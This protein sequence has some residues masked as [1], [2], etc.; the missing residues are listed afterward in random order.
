MV[1]TILGEEEG[2]LSK[3]EGLVFRLCVLVCF[4]LLI[5]S[6]FSLHVHD[7][8]ILKSELIN[9]N[10][11]S[12]AQFHVIK[13]LILRLINDNRESAGLKSQFHVFRGLILRLINDKYE[14]LCMARE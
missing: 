9:N 6:N 10:Y 4:A 8:Q 14:N 7:D 3:N 1:V 13:G 11:E 12:E 5:Y 2:F